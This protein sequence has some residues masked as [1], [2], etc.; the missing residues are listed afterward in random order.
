[1]NN[2]LAIECATDICTVALS[3]N[4]QT[5]QQLSRETRSNA[6][7]L[8]PMVSEL[9]S[10]S[11]L[12]FENLSAICVTTGPGSFTGIRIGLSV[13]QGLAYGSGLPVYTWTTLEVMAA[14]KLLTTKEPQ[15]EKSGKTVI[16]A[17]D[18]R[19]GEI[20]WSSYGLHDSQQNVFEANFFEQDPPCLCSI[21]NFKQILHEKQRSGSVIG[22]GSGFNGLAGEMGNDNIHIDAD[23]KPEA[24]S[25]IDV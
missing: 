1:M 24:R 22:L 17:L 13:V 2:I 7:V 4:G 23:A 8:L 19:M 11:S 10:S 3:V 12:S 20:Y 6:K 25:M 9:L 14:A 15:K 5:Q 21:A 18:A 16:A